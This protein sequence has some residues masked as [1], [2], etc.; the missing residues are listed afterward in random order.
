MDDNDITATQIQGSRKKPLEMIMQN[1]AFLADTQ[2]FSRHTCSSIDKVCVIAGYKHAGYVE[3]DILLDIIKEGLMEKRRV[4]D[5]YRHR[6]TLQRPEF[7]HAK[8]NERSWN[9]GRALCQRVG[10]TVENFYDEIAAK[11]AVH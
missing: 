4:I 11:N 1:K 5:G 7:G 3:G 10:K 9:F 2:F 8:S 6:L